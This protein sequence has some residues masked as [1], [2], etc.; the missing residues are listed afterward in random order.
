ALVVSWL[1]LEAVWFP[2]LRSPVFPKRKENKNNQALVVSWLRLEAV[3]FPV[4]RSPV[5]PKRKENKNN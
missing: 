4:L 1:R 2:V 3:W 5:F